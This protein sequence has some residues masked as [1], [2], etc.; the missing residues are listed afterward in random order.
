MKRTYLP[1]VI[2]LAS[3]QSAFADI[4]TGGGS[5]RYTSEVQQN[6]YQVSN[7]ERQKHL[8]NLGYKRMTDEQMV[9][10][11]AT[12]FINKHGEN[13]PPGTEITVG[14]SQ[15]PITIGQAAMIADKQ[16]GGRFYAPS[17][18]RETPA[19]EAARKKHA[20][21]YWASLEAQMK[22][23]LSKGKA[24]PVPGITKPVSAKTAAPIAQKPT[25]V[26]APATPKASG[27]TTLP[28]RA[29]APRAVPQ[30]PVIKMPQRQTVI[31]KNP[32]IHEALKKKPMRY[33]PHGK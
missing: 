13:P 19:Q 33:Q 25:T 1:L 32:T 18:K 8:R 12:R 3:L 6:Y 11:A 27:P 2:I 10:E 21:E 22:K 20:A 14:Y 17:E 15:R 4:E 24:V 5:D 16:A 7:E 9:A 29:H 30:M 26:I 23:G 31:E 28:N